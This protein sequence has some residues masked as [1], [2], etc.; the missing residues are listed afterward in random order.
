M[1]RNFFKTISS[2][3]QELE[4]YKQE[5]SA[6]NAE[7]NGEKCLEILRE[8]KQKDTNNQINK[9]PYFLQ[10]LMNNSKHLDNPPVVEKNL[11]QPICYYCEGVLEKEELNQCAKCNRFICH[12]RSGCSMLDRNSNLFCLDC[13]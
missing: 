8:K 11:N 4:I 13:L 5:R 2:L 9:L 1:K 7:H 12:L 10:V 3:E 6:D